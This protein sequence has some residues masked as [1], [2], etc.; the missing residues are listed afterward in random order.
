MSTAVSFKTGG[1]P[2]FSLACAC[3]AMGA[4]SLF[5]SLRM[6]LPWAPAINQIFRGAAAGGGDA[7]SSAEASELK[8]CCVQFAVAQVSRIMV[9]AGSLL[10]VSW[11]IP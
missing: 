1:T 5:Q 3:A 2:K 9:V 7:V 8:R 10:S 11:A 6:D 4:L